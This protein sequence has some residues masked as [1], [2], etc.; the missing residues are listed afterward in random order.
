M[1]ECNDA[2]QNRK[3]NHMTKHLGK[4][5]SACITSSAILVAGAL[6][7][8]GNAQE[9]SADP[10]SSES[11]HL[12]EEGYITNPEIVDAA[13]EGAATT[14]SNVSTSEGWEGYI[15]PME[16]LPTWQNPLY[17]KQTR[18][19]GIVSVC[20]IGN[21]KVITSHLPGALGNS[22]TYQCWGG[23]GTYTSSAAMGYSAST[24]VS[25]VC[26]G[27]YAGQIRTE[28]YRGGGGWTWS[29]VRGPYSD[30]YE[31]GPYCHAFTS[32]RRYNAIRLS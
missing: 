8:I 23:T 25:L 28:Y 5:I 12:I 31:K 21:Y 2:F 27:R 4:V 19:P 14:F 29:P 16:L 9:I 13:T 11:V 20:G 1:N 7:P 10:I 22:Y 32:L 15:G 30:N 18:T 26:P 6:V 17:A 3:T 24:G